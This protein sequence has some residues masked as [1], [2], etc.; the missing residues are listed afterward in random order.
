MYVPFFRRVTARC[1]ARTLYTFCATR[2]L[3]LRY[4]NS[5]FPVHAR[6]AFDIIYAVRATRS[7]KILLCWRTTKSAKFEES[8]KVYPGWRRRVLEE[9]EVEFVPFVACVPDRQ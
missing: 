8:K 4:Y 7:S 2:T 5:S 1:R 6:G 3:D 9:D